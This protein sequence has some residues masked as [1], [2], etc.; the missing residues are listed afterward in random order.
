MC[1]EDDQFLRQM[2]SKPINKN[3][4][5]HCTEDLFEEVMNFF[6]QTA[7]TQ[8]PYSTVGDAPAPILTWEE[9]EAAYDENID[10]PARAYAKEIYEHWRARRSKSGNTGVQ[11]SLKLKVIES[12]NDAD[13]NDPYVCFR[14]REVRQVRKTRGR[15]AQSVEKLKK[16]RKE[17]EDARHLVALVNQR[18]TTKRESLAVDRMLYDQRAQLR[19]V[20]QKLPEQ[21]K[22]GDEDL[23]VNQRVSAQAVDVPP[24]LKLTMQQPQKKVASAS[25]NVQKQPPTQL[26]LPP[27]ADGRSSEADLVLLSDLLTEKENR[28]QH[29]IKTKIQQ[30]QK[31]NEN[32]VDMTRVPLTPPL[33]ENFHPSFRPAVTEYLPTPPASVSSEQSEDKVES[34]LE[35]QKQNPTVSVR[36]AAPCFDASN[37]DQPAFRRR[38]GRGGRVM[39]DRRGM[40]S[41]HKV[42]LVDRI[43]ERFKYDMDEDEDEPITYTI[44]PYEI[45]SMRYR[46]AISG[47]HQASAAQAQQ[48][49]AM[50]RAQIEQQQQQQLQHQQQ[51]AQQQQ[52][53]QQPASTAQTAGA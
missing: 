29:E 27:R 51:N 19:S 37:R 30:H 39:I 42:N 17:L 9:M 8:Q 41:Q 38:T 16:L 35:N 20:K 32:Y 48:A 4:A 22:M 14:R 34:S 15:D 13:D 33:E 49:Q 21:Y 45:S 25:N 53:Q 2:N 46:A 18:E 12:A 36:Y 10:E 5:S 47:S 6:E 24:T 23:L 52:Q 1:G 28:I 43:A 7:R 40:Q 26:R 44:E 31:W 50:R 11:P 3:A